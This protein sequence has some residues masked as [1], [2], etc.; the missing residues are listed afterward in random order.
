MANPPNKPNPPVFAASGL[1]SIHVATRCATREE[2]IEQY[3]AF[4]GDDSI[5]APWVSGLMKGTQSRLLIALKDDT[6]VLRGRA[7]VIELLE[8]PN[9]K[10]VRLRLLEL[11]DASHGMQG[12][13]LRQRQRNEQLS[14]AAG[15]SRG[16]PPPMPGGHRP[17]PVP[18][19]TAA[20][21]SDVDP[22]KLAALIESATFEDH[23]NTPPVMTVLPTQE[24]PPLGPNSRTADMAVLSDTDDTTV[25]HFDDGT[26]IRSR[27]ATPV[28][29]PMARSV[30]MPATPLL[31]SRPPT[32][33]PGGL[34]VPPGPTGER[35]TGTTRL[36]AKT[37][38]ARQQTLPLSLGAWATRLGT[39]WN[40]VLARVPEAQ[41]P[42]VAKL[43]PVA[44]IGLAFFVVGRCSV[45]GQELSQDAKATRMPVVAATAGSA[46]GSAFPLAA[47]A[48]PE[49]APA[50]AEAPPAKRP[51]LP[52]CQASV[53]TDPPGAAVFWGDAALG[54]TPL[55][56]AAVPCGRN[57]I[58]IRHPRFDQKVMNVVATMDRPLSISEKLKRPEA[59]VLLTSAPAGAT[60]SIGERKIGTT[61]GRLD[62][63]RY[64]KI[65]VTVEKP[66][67]ERWTQA[68]FVDRAEETIHVRLR[69]E[70]GRKR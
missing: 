5:L 42:L 69:P 40:G 18:G 34:V 1:K 19:G 64:E 56:S 53:T 43:A 25:G 54:E 16:L 39:A 70:R 28:T 51:T 50:G 9:G 60:I 22:D 10:V 46:P 27:D 37:R 57:L 47:A 52:T 3:S 67:F 31:P 26:P 29:V 23:Q 15:A 33:T 58:A 66:G 36:T 45:G 21:G 35:P 2:F 61:P 55:D 8:R 38:V 11:D 68:V 62:V 30:G 32:T 13:L 24:K 17:P 59:S 49:V 41:R 14:A 6:P 65:D 20:P 12:K 44:M 48:T 7:Q 63:E 4:A